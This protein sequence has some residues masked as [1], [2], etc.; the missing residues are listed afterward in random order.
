M[1]LSIVASL[2]ELTDKREEISKK[3]SLLCE[4]LK[5]LGYSGIE[6][7]LLKPEKI[8]TK[9]LMEIVNS[10]DMKIPA[11]G[12][13]GTYIRF[14]YSLGHKKKSI[15]K[16]AIKRIKEYI[17]FAENTASK[18]IIGLIR[19]RYSN[20]SS[21]EKEKE[22]IFSSLT[23]CI[24]LA[25]DQNVMLALEP[26]NRFE[27][28]SYH[29]LS[30]SLELIEKLDSDHIKLLADTFH[31]HLEENPDTIWDYLREN[32]S[33]ICHVHLADCNRRIPGSGHFDF[34]TFINILRN[35]GYNGFY[36]LET[37]MKPSFEDVAEESAKYLR[38]V[39]NE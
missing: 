29:T 3:F 15:R 27:I 23:N 39:F 25:E 28:D 4:Y 30:N 1:N 38:N 13:G 26:I 9:A 17:N 32:A 12:T 22:N 5:P 36:S 37:I 35:A 7:S 21:P 6:I 18:V 2:N 34:K 24:E 19:G 16:K 10:F 8:D 11:L 20:K 33:K 31:I 14:G